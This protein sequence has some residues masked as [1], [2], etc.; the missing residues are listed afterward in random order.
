[1]GVAGSTGSAGDTDDLTSETRGVARWLSPRPGSRHCVRLEWMITGGSSTDLH[2]PQR[3]LDHNGKDGRPEAV[4]RIRVFVSTNGSRVSTVVLQRVLHLL[5]IRSVAPKQQFI[6]SFLA[7]VRL[8][9]F[10]EISV[11]VL[12]VRVDAMVG[13]CHTVGIFRRQN[14]NSIDRRFQIGRT[15]GGGHHNVDGNGSVSRRKDSGGFIK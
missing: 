14:A 13:V 2:L 9:Q 11:D 10:C 7:G 6:D 3:R 8:N 4:L 12:E 1:M 15:L 5:G